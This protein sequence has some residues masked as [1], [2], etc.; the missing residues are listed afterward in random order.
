MRAASLAVVFLCVLGA[1]IPLAYAQIQINQLGVSTFAG[2]DVDS[3]GILYVGDKNFNL[4]KSNDNGT[5]FSKIYTMPGTYD[6]SNPYSGMVWNVFVDSRNNIFASAGGTAGLFRSTNGGTTFSQVLK[7]NG[8]T[9]ESFYIS[10]TEDNSG[11]LYTVTYTNGIATPLILK[12]TDGGATWKIIAQFSVIHYHAIKYN[13]SDGSLYLVTGEGTLPDCAKIF[14]SQDGG[15]TWTTVVQRN[16]TLGTVYLAMA[17]SGRY[18][19]IGQDYPDRICQIMR[20]YDDGSSNII[21]PQVVYTPPNDGYMPMISATTLANSL[22]FANTAEISNGIARI[23]CTTDGTT[24][25]QLSSQSLSYI[26]DNRWNLL[27]VHPRSTIIFGTMRPNEAYNIIDNPNPT[28]TP[29]PTPSPTSSPTPNPTPSRS[30]I[31]TATPTS[32]PSPTPKPPATETPTPPPT[33]T[34]TPTSTPSPLPTTTETPSTI[35]YTT[36]QTQPKTTQKPSTNT[37]TPPP[38]PTTNATD[39][40]LQV[41]TPALTPMTHN[42]LQTDKRFNNIV[43]ILAVTG[44]TC[45][46]VAIAKKVQLKQQTNKH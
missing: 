31:P 10:M 44:G 3:K 4:Y 12:S 19:Y 41:S 13:P 14:R 35:A 16:D 26:T 28:P 29:T 21:T 17:F 15:A 33:P 32:T 5:T 39:D 36:T 43:L 6:P 42:N 34:L 45:A 8:T 9:L 11:N 40:P 38:K 2:N 18:V 30:P 7:T 46:T 1:L 24:W 25:T 20:F 27:T 22:I 37:L 23:V